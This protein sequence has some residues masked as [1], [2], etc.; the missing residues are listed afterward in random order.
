MKKINIILTQAIATLI[1]TS[2]SLPA[3][4]ETENS[5]IP[6]ENSSITTEQIINSSSNG[7]LRRERR[8]I[9]RQR[10]RIIRQVINDAPEGDRRSIRRDVLTVARREDIRELPLPLY[11]RL[12]ELA[13]R[14]H[15]YLPLTAFAE[16]DG[17]SQLVQHYLI[18]TTDFQPNIFT[19]QISGINDQALQT[20]ANF[21]NGGL[22]TIGAIRV[23]LEPKEGLPTDPDDPRAFLDMFTDVSGLFVIN[24]ESGWYEGWMVRD[25]T[26]PEVAEPRSDGSGQAQY[27]TITPKDAEALAAMG[28]GNNTTAGN[29]FTVDG[30]APR[31]PSVND[32]FPTN[33]NNTIPFP[34]SIGAF[35]SQQQSDVHAYWEFNA[36]TNWVFPHYELPFTGGVPGT[37]DDGL[38]YSVTSVVPGSGPEGITNLSEVLGDDPNNPRDPDRAEAEEGSGQRETR[39]RF[40]P[41]R[42]TDE[43]LFNVFLRVKSFLPEVTDTGERLLRSYAQ[44]VAR[45]DTDNDGVVSFAEADVNGTSDGLPNTRLYL[46]PS[47][48]NRFAITREINDA[49]LAPRFAPSTR[50]YVV[51]GNLTLVQP[52]VNASLPRDADDR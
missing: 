42:L 4:S 40:I 41:S 21:A 37:F 18:D 12:L 44:E 10:R 49:L 39:L 27:G 20:G 2:V 13:A 52:S 34:V 33:V 28:T 19:S 17:A 46:P 6:T 32:V 51:S 38:Q 45:I 47:A 15:S 9:R 14:P 35:N 3:L 16:A 31:F 22:P 24:N 26:I 43:V 8:N 30:N 48:F 25:I 29:F 7:R 36:G 23:L 1:F 11:E 50:A 5:S